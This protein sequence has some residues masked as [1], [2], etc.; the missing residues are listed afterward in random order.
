[1]NSVEDYSI[2]G[3]E[4]ASKVLHASSQISGL[5]IAAHRVPI[6]MEICAVDSFTMV[7]PAVPHL[8]PAKKPI[9]C[10]QRVSLDKCKHLLA[11]IPQGHG[12]NGICLWQ[13]LASITA[14][15]S[16]QRTQYSRADTLY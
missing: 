8:N 5:R 2:L 7:Q 6:I 9:S 13:R 4:G 1:M 12:S 16:T 14:T 3:I 15:Q 11:I 10:G